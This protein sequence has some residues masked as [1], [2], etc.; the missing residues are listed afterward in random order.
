MSDNLRRYRA[1]RD[2]L[3]PWSPGQPTGTVARHLP[4]LAALLSGIVG[5]QRTPLPQIATQVPDGTKP[6]SRVKR[7]ARWRQNDPLT[8]AV[9]FGPS[10]EVL[11]R[12]LAWQTLGLVMDGSVG[13]RGCG[14]LMLPVVDTGRALPLAWQGRQGKKGHV[15]EDLPIALVTPVPTLLPLGASVVLLGEGEG[16]G[17][18]L[19]PTLQDAHWSSGVRTG[20][21]IPVRWDGERF[22]GETGAACLT[23]GPGGERTDVRVTEAA[24]GPVRL[25]WCWATGEKE[26]LHRITN[27]A[28]ADEACRLDAKRFRIATFVSDQQRR[29]F[30]RHPS[31]LAAPRRLARW[32]M[33]AC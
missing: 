21:H 5:K 29:G 28:S 10:A 32:L 14:A 2:A 9:Y 8:E 25:L 12:Q 31:H 26:P 19:Q 17:P 20:R 24:D 6:E 18:T 13:G 15:P 27:M 1:I 23:P 7:F 4:P 3:G 30:P 11:L 22:R 33:A 16:E